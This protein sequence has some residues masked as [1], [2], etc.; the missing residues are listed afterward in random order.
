MDLSRACITCKRPMF[1]SFQFAAG[2]GSDNEPMPKK[3]TTGLAEE[4]KEKA[5]PFRET[6]R[7]RKP[8]HNN[9]KVMNG[10][11]FRFH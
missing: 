8:G 1:Q 4:K 3:K 6:W 10:H 5:E 9:N 2:E 11:G 7:G